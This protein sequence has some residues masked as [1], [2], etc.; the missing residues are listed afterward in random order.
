MFLKSLAF[1]A[2]C[3]MNEA[4]AQTRASCEAL[5]TETIPEEGSFRIQKRSLRFRDITVAASRWEN[6]LPGEYEVEIY[7]SYDADTDTLGELFF[8]VGTFAVDEPSEPDEDD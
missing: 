6:L 5:S 2:L 3:M 4:L 8:Q 1:G 7:E